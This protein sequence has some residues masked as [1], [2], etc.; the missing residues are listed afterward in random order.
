M[1]VPV[2]WRQWHPNVVC[3][4]LLLCQE[5]AY[6]LVKL[7]RFPRVKISTHSVIE[8]KVILVFSCNPYACGELSM[9]RKKGCS[10]GAINRSGADRNRNKTGQWQS[11]TA[12]PHSCPFLIA[13]APH[14][15]SMHV[16]S[17]IYPPMPGPSARRR[18]RK[19][20]GN[21]WSRKP[22]KTTRQA[23]PLPPPLPPLKVSCSKCCILN[24][25]RF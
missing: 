23:H 11:N 21:G 12:E 13:L 6:T 9:V 22:K 14:T 25:C 17:G 1:P 20:R 2:F 19:K 8:W 18:R 24:L 7:M 4:V 16:L 3:S 10:N 15:N 5:C